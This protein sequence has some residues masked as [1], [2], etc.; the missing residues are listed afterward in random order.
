M[1]LWFVTSHLLIE[2]RT[3]IYNRSNRCLSDLQAQEPSQSSSVWSVLSHG[4]SDRGWIWLCLCHHSDGMW[5]ASQTGLYSQSPTRSRK[6][7]CL[8]MK[9]T[10]SVKKGNMPRALT[11]PEPLQWW[12]CWTLVPG[13]WPLPSQRWQTASVLTDISLLTPFA[14]W[15]NVS[16]M[17]YCAREREILFTQSIETCTDTKLPTDSSKTVS[18]KF[19][20]TS[21]GWSN[22]ALKSLNPW[23]P[24]NSPKI[25][26][27]SSSGS[28][29]PVCPVQ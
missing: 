3:G 2:M 29:L 14:A 25:L 9:Y 1:I 28:T 20:L 16:S 26:R 13:S 24:E 22:I 19:T 12:Q 27:K 18:H 21:C 8:V 11:M 17:M 5:S 23:P 10:C 6:Y 7:V 4:T 15:V